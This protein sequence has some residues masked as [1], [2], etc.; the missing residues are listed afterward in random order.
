MRFRV[1]A[2]LCALVALLAAA[3]TTSSGSSGTKS[4]ESAI[5]VGT[6]A[7]DFT[8]NTPD[9]QAVTLSSFRGNK[10]VLLYFSMGPG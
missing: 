1:F 2:A 7:P 9:G 6:K 3:C 10:P 5:T 4:P 8:L